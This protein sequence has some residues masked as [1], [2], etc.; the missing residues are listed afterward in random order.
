MDDTQP[1][2][3]NGP[4]MLTREQASDVLGIRLRALHYWRRQNKLLPGTVVTFRR[5]F[6]GH[7]LVRF[8]KSKLEELLEQ[9]WEI[10]EDPVGNAEQAGADVQGEGSSDL[11]E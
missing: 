2:D 9:G 3:P 4:D 5:P 7:P 8:R 1:E 11:E 10:T 6:G